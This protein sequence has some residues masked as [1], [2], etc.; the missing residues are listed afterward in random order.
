M[1][2]HLLKSQA[3]QL[4]VVDAARQGLGGLPDH[5]RRGTAENQEP[6]RSGTAVGQHTQDGE[7]I[8][9]TL[10]FVDDYQSAQFIEHQ[11]RVVDQPIEVR[12]IL[13]V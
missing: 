2:A 8:G 11:Q 4:V 13:K 12:R 3:T 1:V 9:T 10:H 7:Q 6:C 5:V